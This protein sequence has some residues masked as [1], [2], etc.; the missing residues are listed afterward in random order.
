MQRQL[1]ELNGRMWKA[2]HRL[3]N[4]DRIGSAARMRDKWWRWTDRVYEWRFK[5]TPF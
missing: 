3:K 5:T 1:K 4:E 2:Y